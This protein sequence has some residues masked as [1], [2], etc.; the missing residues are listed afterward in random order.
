MTAFIARFSSM[1]PIVGHPVEWPVP[2]E[3]ASAKMK[4]RGRK[5]A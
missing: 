4:P 1:P 3:L 5:Y 2:S